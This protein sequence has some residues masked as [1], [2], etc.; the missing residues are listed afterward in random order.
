RL[1][2][3]HDLKT[4]FEKVKTGENGWSITRALGVLLDVCNAL[5]Y[6]HSKGII[7]RDIK[8]SNVMVGKYGET[9]VMDWGLAKFVGRMDHRALRLRLSDETNS[10]RT[11][12]RD[13]GMESP[14]VTMDGEVIGTPAYMPPEQAEGRIAELCPASDVY[15]VGAMLYTLLAG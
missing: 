12:R 15:S 13:S 8:P 11:D 7:H 6:A 9:Y 10:V 1:V 2:K 3:G 14:I 4:I 5:A